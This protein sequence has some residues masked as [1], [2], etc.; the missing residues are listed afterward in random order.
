MHATPSTAIIDSV[1]TSVLLAE[2]F[3]LSEAVRKQNTYL[4]IWKM[5]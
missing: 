3:K 1:Q 2:D 5:C 4:L